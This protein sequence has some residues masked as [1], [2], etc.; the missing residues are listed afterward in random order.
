MESLKQVNFFSL[1]DDDVICLP[2]GPAKFSIQLAKSN[3]TI[4]VLE[5]LNIENGIS[6]AENL[7]SLVH[8]EPR[9]LHNSIEIDFLG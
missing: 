5:A 2:M 8:K 6:K 7:L 3:L 4:G 9:L 1:S